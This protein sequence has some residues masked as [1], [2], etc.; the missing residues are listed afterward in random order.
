MHVDQAVTEEHKALQEWFVNEAEAIKGRFL[1][2]LSFE[3][4]RARN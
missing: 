1:P 4:W 3:E 2:D